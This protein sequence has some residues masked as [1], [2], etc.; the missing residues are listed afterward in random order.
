MIQVQNSDTK[1]RCKAL[2]TIPYWS[3]D[4]QKRLRKLANV[5]SSSAVR[6]VSFQ[7]PL[8]LAQS[9]EAWPQASKH[10]SRIVRVNVLFFV[11]FFCFLNAGTCVDLVNNYTC[12]CNVGFTGRHCKIAI[13]HCS[14]DSCYPGVP[15]FKNG[16]SISCGSCPSGYQ[17]NGKNCKGD[18]LLIS[19][20]TQCYSKREWPTVYVMTQW[21]LKKK[22]KTKTKT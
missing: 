18:N 15:C 20:V 19:R 10:F 16:Y 5:R 7:K 3:W 21:C 13:T 9:N 6:Y 1:F 4:A 12:V 17:G 11:F 2:E 22:Q 14:K 8:Y